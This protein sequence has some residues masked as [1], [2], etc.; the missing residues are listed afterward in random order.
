MIRYHGYMHTV[1]SEVGSVYSFGSNKFGEL[2]LVHPTPPYMTTPT[3][4]GTLVDV[5]KVACGR[6]HSAAIDSE[7]T[8]PIATPI[9]MCS[10]DLS[11][12]HA[13]LSH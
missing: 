13:N 7:L 9:A 3:Q 12:S 1:V 10:N 5:V 6:L 8:T 11:H 4:I 2:G